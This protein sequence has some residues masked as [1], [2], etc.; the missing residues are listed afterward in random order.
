MIPTLPARQ[1]VLNCK[2]TAT[3]K[4]SDR[5]R[6]RALLFAWDMLPHWNGKNVMSSY[7]MVSKQMHAF[8]AG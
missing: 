5:S 1:G 8:L 2:V 4:V 6:E 3:A 7:R